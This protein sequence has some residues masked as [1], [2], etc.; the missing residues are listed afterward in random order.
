MT[1]PVRPYRLLALSGG[2]LNGA[3]GIGV[4]NGW[5]E[6]GTRPPFDVVTGTSAGAM[7]ATFEFLGPQYDDLLRREGVGL[8][9]SDILHRRSVFVLPFADAVFSSH[10]I[11][12]RLERLITPELLREVAT[13]HAAGRRLYVGTTNLDTRR[14]VIWDMGAIASRGTPAAVDLYRRIIL[15]SASIPG[16]FPP[17]RI[18]VE[19]DGNTYE[20]L[21]ADGGLSEGVFFRPFMVEELN[22]LNGRSGPTA[23]PGSTL[24]VISHWKMYSNPSCVRPFLPSLLSTATWANLHSKVRGDLA[25]VYLECLR[26]GVEYRATAIPEDLPVRNELLRL[27]RNEQEEL[28]EAGRTI[29]AGGPTGPEWRDHP[30]GYDIGDQSRPRTGTVFVTRQAE[31]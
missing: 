7:I 18:P 5:S 9:T 23:V 26:A 29:G 16:A 20:E 22:R 3:F 14:F 12:H 8:V 1:G 6:S 25:R 4:L 15:A 11:E 21:H 24:Y 13:A 17:V 2:G 28:F 19:I 10:P 30:P 31:K 27:N